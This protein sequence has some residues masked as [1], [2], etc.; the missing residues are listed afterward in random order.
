[1]SNGRT[2][3]RKIS[4]EG[5]KRMLKFD[6]ARKY[7]VGLLTVAMVFS[8][9]TLPIATAAPSPT[10]NAS[11]WSIQIDPG[12]NNETNPAD[13]NNTHTITIYTKLGETLADPGYNVYLAVSDGSVIVADPINVSKTST[14]VFTGTLT[15]GTTVSNPGTYFIYGYIDTDTS[16]TLSA[17]D[18]V[19]D[20]HTKTWATRVISSITPTLGTISYSAT[21]N[22]SLGQT[23]HTITVEVKDQFKGLVSSDTLNYNITG[24]NTQSGTIAINSG[25]ATLSY[26]NT[27]TTAESSGVLGHDTIVLS[28]G[29]GT[30]TFYKTW[31]Y[32]P[33][34][35]IVTVD[36]DGYGTGTA[37]NYVDET[38]TITI[39]VT[40][41]YGL[42]YT[43][44]LTLSFTAANFSGDATVTPTS[45]T[46][47]TNTG[48][49]VLNFTNANGKAGTTGVTLTPS[50][51]SFGETST[52]FDK[53][54]GYR[55]HATP[56][57]ET[58]LIGE[59]HT[60]T[61]YGFP[62]DPIP[63]LSKITGYPD[64]ANVMT[65][66]TTS[67]N[68][69]P[70][71]MAE[72]QFKCKI[73]GTYF[74]DFQGVTHYINGKW[75]E[76][77]TTYTIEVKKHWAEMTSITVTPTLKIN[78]LTLTDADTHEV[79]A[80]V[81]GEYPLWPGV[82]VPPVPPPLGGHYVVV[83]DVIWVVDAPISGVPVTFEVTTSN[84]AFTPV[85]D[86]ETAYT[87]SNG[88]ATFSYTLA[89]NS[90]TP[91]F[92]VCEI[93]DSI[94]VTANYGDPLIAAEK[95]SF[96][97][98]VEKKWRDHAFKVIKY[99]KT[100]PDK[101]LPGAKLFLRYVSD[102]LK[103]ITTTTPTYI[104]PTNDHASVY[105]SIPP[106]PGVVTTDT[107]GAAIWY[108][109]P[110]GKYA[111]Y[112]Y[113]A[114]TGY[115]PIPISDEIM[116]F[117]VSEDS[118]Y[119]CGPDPKMVIFSLDNTPTTP[120]IPVTP[121]GTVQFN[122]ITY[123]YQYLI[124]AKFQAENL[125][126]SA[127]Y[128]A[129]SIAPNGLVK[130]TNLP[131]TNSPSDKDTWYKVTEIS[132]PSTDVK[133]VDPFFFR[134]DTSGNW[135]DTFYA[136]PSTTATKV[137]PLA[138]YEALPPAHYVINPKSVDGAYPA[139]FT[140]LPASSSLVLPGNTTQNLT[141]KVLDQTL[142]PMVGKTVNLSTDFGT[143]SAPSVV[144]GADGTAPFS[145]STT[146]K[147][148]GTANITGTIVLPHQTYNAS[149]TVNWTRSTPVIT[150][151]TLQPSSVTLTLPG[152]K[153]QS[154]LVTVLD[155]YGDGM[156]GQV[157]N[158]WSDFGLLSNTNLYTN[159]LGQ[160]TFNITSSDPGVAHISATA[161]S[162][163]ATA[164][165]TWVLPTPPPEPTLYQ[166]SLA[167]GWN[168][169]TPGVSS[170]KTA[171]ELFGPNLQG[172]FHYDPTMPGPEGSGGYLV[173]TNQTLVPGWGY[174]VKMSAAYVADMTGTAVASPKTMALN[175]GWEQIGN[176]FEV[177]IAVSKVS[178]TKNFVTKSLA[179]ALAAGWI[180]PLFSYDGSA[181]QILDLTS[182]VLHKGQGFWVKV[183]V[184][185]CSITYTR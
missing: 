92:H 168:L 20:P 45:G 181:Y 87:D 161:D 52:T 165:V 114:P 79:S 61:V 90:G 48:V 179:D 170:S 126:T 43:G 58:N 2:L 91:T 46:I 55:P 6:L 44:T 139:Y 57:M 172:V 75:S 160:A 101:L 82:T 104:P 116:E 132:V 93:T 35:D 89:Y 135:D 73:P 156:A 28:G 53:V 17:N 34:P 66:S 67:G 122:K 129:T 162:K 39:T 65:V 180:S 7:L 171:A 4:K 14:G 51:F 164:T 134:L 118:P 105:P 159:S 140:I 175:K 183:L 40:D 106:V 3:Q 107:N 85:P 33:H 127:T 148:A 138:T 103:T 130:W 1:M 152:Q 13:T 133:L 25:V 174:W 178:I 86:E 77:T 100:N 120:T 95:G 37:Y 60:I 26:S 142:A 27:D 70:N 102:P 155:Q 84:A 15:Y 24:S 157:V 96:S 177:D 125:T 124:G 59:I 150:T 144:T 109:L 16:T 110:Y 166:L 30:A 80:T 29:N 121:T 153:S 115:N 88:V 131:A 49:F 64:L 141:V 23:T 63:I 123:C 182:G 94:K 32:T 136:A 111:L 147:G 38:Q 42:P 56:E 143:L 99:D 68:F 128:P 176:P 69:P 74:F 163:F 98:T 12:N 5:G 167:A 47:T 149:A 21:N 78:A 173:C 71:G 19:S 119:W 154:F 117:V 184:D 22:V 9:F 97:Q 36:N 31:T 151:V 83:A 11:T 81:L 137:W 50:G 112:E 108:H 41:T 145:I 185:G 76:T 146:I 62:G 169:V 8:L 10:V 158:I 18:I 113:A 54:W 72:F